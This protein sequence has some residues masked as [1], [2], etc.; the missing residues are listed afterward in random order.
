MGNKYAGGKEKDGI[1]KQIVNNMNVYEKE[2]LIYNQDNNYAI[3]AFLM[4]DKKDF[5]DNFLDR[6]VLLQ[7]L[8]RKNRRRP[9]SLALL[10]KTC[11]PNLEGLKILLGD[12]YLRYKEHID[13]YLNLQLTGSKRFKAIMALMS[14]PNKTL[15]R[16]FTNQLWWISQNF[17]V[18]LNMIGFNMTTLILSKLMI[19]FSHCLQI[20]IGHSIIDLVKNRKFRIGNKAKFNLKVLELNGN[21]KFDKWLCIEI[22][23]G[24]AE[25]ESLKTSL[26]VFDI[27][28][29]S[30]NCSTIDNYLTNAGFDVNWIGEE[31]Y[32][33]DE[34]ENSESENDEDE[35]FDVQNTD[36]KVK[37]DELG[38]KKNQISQQQNDDQLMELDDNE[39]GEQNQ[40]LEEQNSQ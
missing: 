5:V 14:G 28:N 9:H 16:S 25:N 38:D 8:G 17:T 15:S 3:N 24:M 40:T 4:S 10:C 27:G 13:N 11:K 29:T 32:D 12:S 20:S 31:I 26:K 7:Q 33:S 23:D 22:I 21:F 37:N 1:Q 39:D 6:N 19:A 35:N 34:C 30:T 18:E 36:Q 2:I